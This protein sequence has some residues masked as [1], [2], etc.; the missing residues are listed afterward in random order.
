ML[1]YNLKHIKEIRFDV[2][3]VNGL[4]EGLSIESQGAIFTGFTS[5]YYYKKDKVDSKLTI[6]R[7]SKSHLDIRMNHQKIK[8]KNHKMERCIFSWYQKRGELL[9]DRES[10]F[11]QK[12]LKDE[13]FSDFKF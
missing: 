4:K 9:L 3:Y 5:M 2:N 7:R 6:F 12:D 13:C 11:V 1:N 8:D 10:S